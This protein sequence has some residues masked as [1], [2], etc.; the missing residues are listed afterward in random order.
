[1][2][3]APNSCLWIKAEANW[4]CLTCQDLLAMWY[5]TRRI[6]YCVW[7]YFYINNSF[8][9]SI[10]FC[11]HL[12]HTDTVRPGIESTPLLCNPWLIH[13]YLCHQKHCVRRSFI[14]A[15]SINSLMY[16]VGMYICL[17]YYFFYWE[18]SFQNFF[19]YKFFWLPPQLGYCL[20]RVW[21]PN[22]GFYHNHSIER[23]R[24]M[25]QAVMGEIPEIF[26]DDTNWPWLI[27]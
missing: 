16:S 4:L 23:E 20:A 8:Y 9:L 14:N 11:T 26:L 12:C 13:K 22:A 19:P 6:T 3:L 2:C 10:C 27:H 5:P 25:R 21:F 15:L 18:H 17:F 7:I 1:M 24:F